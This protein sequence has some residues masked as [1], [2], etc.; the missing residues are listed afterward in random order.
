M[1]LKEGENEGEGS[2]DL[3]VRMQRVLTMDPEQFT[4]AAER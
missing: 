3:A 2:R 1:T 4:E